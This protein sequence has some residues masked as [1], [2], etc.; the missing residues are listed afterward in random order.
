MAIKAAD[1]KHTY[2]LLTQKK[3]DLA[4]TI[5]L[6]KGETNPQAVVMRTKFEIQRETISAIMD[7]IN[8]NNLYLEIL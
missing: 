5:E 3:A 4:E 6:F 7:S 8:G 1:A 2:K